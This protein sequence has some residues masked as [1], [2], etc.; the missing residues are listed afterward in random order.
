MINADLELR[1]LDEAE[2]RLVSP[3]AVLITEQEVVLGTAAALQARPATRRRRWI[4]AT[5]AFLAAVEHALVSPTEDARPKRHDYPKH[6]SWLENA[7]MAREMHR[8]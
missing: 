7:A 1:T 5:S 3:T 2:E 4:E 8:L 6:Y